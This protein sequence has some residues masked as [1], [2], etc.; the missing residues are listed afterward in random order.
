[1]ILLPERLNDK[2]IELY[3]LLNEDRYVEYLFYG[4][5]RAGK[6]FLIF[7]WFVTQCIRYGANCLIIRNTFTSLNN[8]MLMQTVPAVLNSISRRWGYSDYKKVMIGGERFARYVNKDDSLVFYNGSY[9]KF[10]SLRG[11]SDSESKYDSILS[12]EW[13]H[14]FLDEIS[15]ISWRRY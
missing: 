8:G 15:E 3:N 4:S 7:A 1:M 12:T 5:S 9:I 2:Q 10:G 13:G 11:S 6:T 14:I